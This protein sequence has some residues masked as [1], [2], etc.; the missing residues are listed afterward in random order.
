MLPRWDETSPYLLPALAVGG[1]FY[2][3][4]DVKALCEDGQATF[5]PGIESAVVTQVAEYPRGRVCK[6]WLAGGNLDE[7]RVMEGMISHLMARD[8]GVSKFTI[9]GR[10]GWSRVLP[11]YRPM[12]TIAMKEI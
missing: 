10:A 1:D 4:G 9:E 8:H 3:I 12:S 6:Y 7:L 2:D 11:G 5:W